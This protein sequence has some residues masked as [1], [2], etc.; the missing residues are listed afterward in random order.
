MSIPVSMASSSTV[1]LTLNSA[2]GST[3]STLSY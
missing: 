2:L 1:S 3:G